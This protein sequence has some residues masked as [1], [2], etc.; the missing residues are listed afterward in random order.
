MTILKRHNVVGVLASGFILM[1]AVVFVCVMYVSNYTFDVPV[2]QESY[3]S[4]AE[5]IDNMEAKKTRILHQ[6]QSLAD[7]FNESEEKNQYLLSRIFDLEKDNLMLEESLSS[8]DCTFDYWRGKYIE[9][10]NRWEAKK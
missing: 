5:A 8:T 9:M 6:F 7:R 4:Q 3:S 10:R 2:L 1:L